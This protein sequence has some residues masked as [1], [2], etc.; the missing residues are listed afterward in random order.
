MCEANCWRF[1]MPG[2]SAWSITWLLESVAS[3]DLLTSE[4]RSQPH[5]AQDVGDD[6]G[7]GVSDIGGFF[8]GLGESALENV[9]GLNATNNCINRDYQTCHQI[10]AGAAADYPSLLPTPPAQAPRT[11][12]CAV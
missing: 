1:V 2:N 3:C 10:G 8:V 7:F 6:S 12:W 4:P 11:M 9:Q 5:A